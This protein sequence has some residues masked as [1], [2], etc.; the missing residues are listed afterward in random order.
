MKTVLRTEKNENV[1]EK[2]RIPFIDAMRGVAVLLMIGVHAT[3]AFLALPF[4]EGVWWS[5][6]DIIFGFVAPAFLFLSGVTLFI[7]V[8]RRRESGRPLSGLWLRALAILALGYWLHI[9]SHSLWIALRSSPAQI[10]Q[11]FDC[12]ILQLISFSMLLVLSFVALLRNLRWS[13]WLALG[14]GVLIAAIAPLVWNAENIQSLP[15]WLR[16]YFS[17]SGSFPI[18]PYGAYFLIGFGG[19]AFLLEGSK[20]QFGAMAVAAIGLGLI[21]ASYF[22]QLLLDLFPLYDN[23]W[24]GSPALILFRLGGVLLVTGGMIGFEKVREKR[25]WLERVGGASLALYV[26][27]LMLVYGSPVTMGMR[28]W[29]NLLLYRALNPF[30]TIVLFAAVVVVLWFAVDAWRRFRER[31][32]VWSLRVFWGWWIG[33]ALF[34]LL[35]GWW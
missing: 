7:A 2:K 10:D 27:H 21:F 23:F 14:L 25:A 5:R 17:S 22:L 6:I 1:G 29:F 32:P 30:Q 9:P 11:F 15:V 16:F 19:A 33:F 34:F 4:R 28:Y 13:A 26:L 24:Q 3:D 20:K 8:S 31:Y 35:T 12:D 18:F